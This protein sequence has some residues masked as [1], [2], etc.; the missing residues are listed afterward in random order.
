MRL[1]MEEKWLMDAPVSR[2]VGNGRC[3][4]PWSWKPET[5]RDHRTLML[6]PKAT[7]CAPVFDTNLHRATAA[8]PN[9]CY[10]RH[11]SL[12]EPLAESGDACARTLLCCASKIITKLFH[13]L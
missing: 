1:L 7:S 3:F 11:P 13:Q 4:A 2:L 8:L 6:A 12:A 10:K 9:L 5:I